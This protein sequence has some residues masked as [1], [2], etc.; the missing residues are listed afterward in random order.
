LTTMTIFDLLD[1]QLQAARGSPAASSCVWLIEFACLYHG[2]VP[3][4]APYE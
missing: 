3:C 1:E 4:A 2:V